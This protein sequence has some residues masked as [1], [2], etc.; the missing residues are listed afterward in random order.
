ML[1][2]NKSPYPGKEKFITVIVCGKN[3]KIAFSC[4]KLNRTVRFPV[5][6]YVC[7]SYC[8]VFRFT[9]V[10]LSLRQKLL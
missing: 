3:L 5:P 8:F 2:E 10:R 7:M 9:G 4:L 1:L 6:G